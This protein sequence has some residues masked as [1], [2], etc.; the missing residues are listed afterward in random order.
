LRR[1]DCVVTTA[2]PRHC[3]GDQATGEHSSPLRLR[4]STRC[5]S[6]I[7]THSGIIRAS[8]RQDFRFYECLRRLSTRNASG[9]M[10]TQCRYSDCAAPVATVFNCVCRRPSTRCPSGIMAHSGII[11]ASTRQDFRFYECLRRSW[12][13]A[14]SISLPNRRRNVKFTLPR[15]KIRVNASA[16]SR[17]DGFSGRS[18]TSLSSIKFK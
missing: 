17:R 16:L 5:P 9:I 13:H 3:S 7:M 6:G 18:A 11:R 2:Q 15:S 8:T 14:A 4:P 12:P 1:R 10:T